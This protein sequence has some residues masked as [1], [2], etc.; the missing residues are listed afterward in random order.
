MSD[1]FL[2]KVPESLAVAMEM[3]AIYARRPYGTLEKAIIRCAACWVTPVDKAGNPTKDPRN[4]SGRFA[5]TP[6]HEHAQELKKLGF[7]TECAH[8]QE[9]L[10]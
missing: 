5:M 2:E 10:K 6:C 1:R 9:A 7:A 3:A 8:C 4:V